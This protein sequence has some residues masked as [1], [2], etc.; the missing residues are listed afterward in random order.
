MM[1]GERWKEKYLQ[2]LLHES[3]FFRSLVVIVMVVMGS[4]EG[5]GDSSGVVVVVAEVVV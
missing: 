2:P 1:R 4:G 5:N 3:T